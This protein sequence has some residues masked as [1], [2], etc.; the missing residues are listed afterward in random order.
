MALSNWGFA[1]GFCAI[2]C[3]VMLGTLDL[4]E[5]EVVLS[6]S[7]YFAECHLYSFFGILGQ[8]MELVIQVVLVD[9]RWGRKKA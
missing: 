2:I 3:P 8:R 6:Q 5:P 4:I 7:G 1:D 9:S